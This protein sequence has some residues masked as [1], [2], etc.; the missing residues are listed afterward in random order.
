MGTPFGSQPQASL[1][2]LPGTR[3]R[4]AIFSTFLRFQPMAFSGLIFFFWG[5]GGG[6]G[7]DASWNLTTVTSFLPQSPHRQLCVLATLALGGRGHGSFI[8]RGIGRAGCENSYVFQL[9]LHLSWGFQ[10]W[11][12]LV[13]ERKCDRALVFLMSGFQEYVLKPVRPNRCVTL[14]Q[15]I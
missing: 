2:D 13:T 4:G 15:A 11:G 7:S 1:S 5:G 14:T 9:M 3:R 6:A 12:K 10:G 8:P